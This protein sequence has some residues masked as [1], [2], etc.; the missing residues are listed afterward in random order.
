[1]MEKYLFNFI[2]QKAKWTC[3]NFYQSFF[4]IIYISRQLRSMHARVVLKT[5]VLIKKF[6]LF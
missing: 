3:L 1:M 4:Y 6:A 2:Q 5:F